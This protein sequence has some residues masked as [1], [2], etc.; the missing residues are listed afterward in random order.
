[1]RPNVQTKERSIWDLQPRAMTRD[2]TG[3]SLFRVEG[4][5]HLTYGS[6]RRSAGI[7]NTARTVRQRSRSSFGSWQKWW[8]DPETLPRPLHR[9]DTFSTASFSPDDS[10]AH[11]VT[12]CPTMC[13]ANE[14]PEPTRF[15]EQELGRG[16][17][18]TSMTLK[19]SGRGCGCYVLTATHPETKDNN[20]TRKDFS[21]AQQIELV[22]VYGTCELCA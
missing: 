2:S 7:S 9:K 1:M 3:A 5:R 18:S 15:H 10:K 22:A 20:F 6:M 4:Q 13:R 8:Q 17:M 12:S 16:S 11:G 21:G 19:E 14:I